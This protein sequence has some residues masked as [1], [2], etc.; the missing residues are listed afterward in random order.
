M[1]DKKSY[2]KKYCKD[3]K[4]R[5]RKK[6]SIDIKYQYLEVGIMNITI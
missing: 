1:F 2:M 6:D 4:D 3:N 5:I